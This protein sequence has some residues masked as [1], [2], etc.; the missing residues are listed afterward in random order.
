L[1]RGQA[2]LAAVLLLALSS[3]FA[4]ALLASWLLRLRMTSFPSRG[5]ES[6]VEIKEMLHVSWPLLAT[7]LTVFSLTQADIWVLGMFSGQ[8]EVAVYGAASR[9]ALITFFITQ[10]LYAVLPP[11]IAEKY[12][13][14]EREVL[15]R[16][17]RASATVAA[18]FAAPIL[19]AFVL[20]SR[21]VLGVVY[22]D[23]YE[24]GQWILVLLSLG[25]FVNVATGIRGYVLMMVGDER[26]QLLISI[27]GGAANVVMCTLGA[28][29]LGM[30][31]VAL[32]AMISLTAQCIAEL[33]VVYLRLGIRTY[34]FLRP[35]KSIRRLIASESAQ[36]K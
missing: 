9:L 28:I 13:S 23:Y 19:I 12:A 7:N 36:S 1:A 35:V 34:A 33:L 4:S 27:A 6:R 29:Y 32:A 2:S 14:N 15:E 8:E 11:I 30:I 17:L 31:G 22:G 5:G 16:L 10:I 25:A 24:S 20:F 3:G 26:V 21:G 18:L